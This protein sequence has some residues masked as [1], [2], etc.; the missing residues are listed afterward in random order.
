MKETD[1]NAEITEISDKIPI[2]TDLA[3]TS[4]FNVVEN[5]I[6]N[7]SDLV[8]KLIMMQKIS[9]IETKYFTIVDCNKCMGEI[10]NAKIKQ[11]GLVNK[12]DISRFKD[13]SYLE[14]R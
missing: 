14:K 10:L 11:R 13:N 2:I 3:T 7:F 12:S 8:K 6:L 5:K 1:Y 4:V 9:N